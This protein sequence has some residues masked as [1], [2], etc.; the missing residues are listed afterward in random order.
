MKKNAKW[1]VKKLRQCVSL[2]LEL[3]NPDL[4]LQYESLERD[5]VRDLCL[6]EM[7]LV[8]GYLAPGV[9]LTIEEWRSVVS[10]EIEGGDSFSESASS[11]MPPKWMISQEGVLPLTIIS[12]S[13]GLLF[14]SKSE[15]VTL[16]GVLKD[17]LKMPQARVIAGHKAKLWDFNDWLEA[18]M[19][20][21]GMGPERFV[22]RRSEKYIPASLRSAY[23]SFLNG[24]PAK[25]KQE[26][27]KRIQVRAL[28]WKC[29]T[30]HSK[31]PLKG[32]KGKLVLEGLPVGEMQKTLEE[33]QN[34]LLPNT[35]AVF[36]GGDKR[37]PHRAVDRKRHLCR[38]GSEA[39]RDPG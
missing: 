10:S 19:S 28:I 11:I 17:R 2:A 16:S 38:R 34:I 4:H 29:S 6:M 31:N 39:R 22:A 15:Y 24:T 32:K 12:D 14:E 35:E 8:A 36:L 33:L 23:K 9:Q 27:T 5:L 26:R 37:E 7:M 21:K 3:L 20:R 30:M 1:W 18:L 13:C 25:S